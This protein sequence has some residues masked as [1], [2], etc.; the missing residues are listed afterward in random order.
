[1]S[2]RSAPSAAMRRAWASAIEGSKNCPPSENE[3]GVTFRMPITAGRPSAS[4]RSSGCGFG[5]AADCASAIDA[6]LRRDHGEVK[7]WSVADLWVEPLGR[8]DPAADALLRR[9][10]LHAL[11]PRVGC[12]HRLRELGRIAVFQLANSIDAGVL[13]Q[14]RIGL[15]DTLDPHPVGEIGPAQHRLLVDT[16]LLGQNLARFCSLRGFKK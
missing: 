15:A 8:L 13:E 16:K 4:S 6:A 5:G 10:Q 2:R 7:S 3:S 12:G 14:L 11:A 9:Q 1:M